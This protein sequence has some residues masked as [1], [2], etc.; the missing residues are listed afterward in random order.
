[1]CVGGGGDIIMF[2]SGQVGSCHTHMHSFQDNPTL[3]DKT[4][5]LIAFH[6]VLGLPELPTVSLLTTPLTS[7]NLLSLGTMGGQR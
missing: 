7:V 2:V 4:A 6:N 3:A 5:H 1:M